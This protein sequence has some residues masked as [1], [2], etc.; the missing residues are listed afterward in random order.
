MEPERHTTPVPGWNPVR[1][2]AAALLVLAA[3]CSGDREAPGIARVVLVTV[4]TLRADH[5]GCYGYP[6]ATSPAI[7]RLAREGLVFEHAYASSALTAPSHASLFTGLAPQR[8]RLLVNGEDLDPGL[9]HLAETLRG[10]GFETAAFTSV[11]FLEGVAK[12]F[13][14]VDAGSRAGREAAGAALRWLADERRSERFFLWLHLFDLHGWRFGEG[15]DPAALARVR[16]TSSAPA[17]ELYAVLEELH[18]FPPGLGEPGTPAWSWGAA[19]MPERGPTEL[20]MGSV[21]EALERLDHYDARLRTADE[22]VGRLFAALRALE[23]PGEE[24]WIVTAD[25]G[26]GLGSHGYWGHGMHLY[27]EQLRVPLVLWSSAGR[28]EPGRVEPLARLVDLPPTV[29]EL[30]DLPLAGAAL[31]GA[32]LLPLIEGRGPARLAFAQRRPVDGHALALGWTDETLHALQDGRHKYVRHGGGGDELYD[33]RDD[34][35]ER[36]NLAG[37]APGTPEAEALVR[38]RRALRRTLEAPPIAAGAGAGGGI[39]AERLAE[40]QALGYAGEE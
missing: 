22:Q 14:T 37:A 10:A 39:P 5:L 36:R 18:G 35:R 23:L 13:D 9:P 1:A 33:L 6:R 20:Q 3:S 16:E 11:A 25:H 19:D 40:L 28:F 30:L 38:L 21:G 26:E 7:D 31:E 8:H 15:T 4:D 17:G 32:S 34:P 2:A 27:N 24:L 29:C 12:G